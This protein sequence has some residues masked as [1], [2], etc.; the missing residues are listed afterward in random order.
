MWVNKPKKY[1]DEEYPEL[2]NLFKNKEDA[3]NGLYSTIETIFICPCCLKEYKRKIVN[4][5]KAGHVTCPTC[6]DGFPYPEKFMANLLTQ[7][8][9][10]FDYH[11][12]DTWTQ[13]YIYDFRLEFNGKKYIIETD[14]GI[15]HGNRNLTNLSSEESLAIDKYK[16]LL[17]I[18]NGYEIIRIDC[19]YISNRFDYIKQSIID[20]LYD[21]IDLSMVDWNECNKRALDSMFYKVIDCYKYQSQFVDDIAE[22]TQIKPRTIV[23]YLN[24]AMDCGILQKHKI[25]INN[26]YKDI[27]KG[28]KFVF[29][30][31]NYSGRNKKIYCYE[32]VILFNSITDASEYYG[33]CRGSID[34][35]IKNHDGYLKGKHFVY[36]DE[37][38]EDFDFQS[39][40]DFK[41]LRNQQ[42]YQYTKDLQLVG[43]YKN[44]AE[45]QSKKQQYHYANIWRVCK[46]QRKTA[47]GFIWSFNILT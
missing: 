38:S 8:D 24:E 14:G 6:S 25:I 43:L 16:D 47:Y 41:V 33:F 18:E 3:H 11:Y 46:G 12:T 19:N 2:V 36:F 22:H 20:A 17:A 21:I 30:E 34:A 27:P 32:D 37:L 4:V 42:I 44:A 31:Q 29:N 39:K 7:L 1:V 26:P 13:N 15:G 5:V 9:I 45:L 35:A 40:T 28:V 23:K 10:A